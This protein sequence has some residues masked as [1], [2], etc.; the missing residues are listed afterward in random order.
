MNKKTYA[1]SAEDKLTG[2]KPLHWAAERNNSELISFLINQYGVS[3]NVTDFAGKTPL[4]IASERGNLLSVITL[5][6]DTRINLEAQD[7]NGKTPL[8]YAIEKKHND[9]AA[10]LIKKNANL[11]A[12]DQEGKTPL[13]VQF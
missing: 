12:L 4:H 11:D 13:Q 10:E 5:L 9:V 7:Q 2:Y 3:A 6:K 1:H 8:H